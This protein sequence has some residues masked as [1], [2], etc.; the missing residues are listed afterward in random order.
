[1]DLISC[2]SY[3]MGAAELHLVKLLKISQNSLNLFT[4]ICS[5]LLSSLTDAQNVLLYITSR[6]LL[7]ETLLKD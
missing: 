1:M 2:S 5:Q 7:S 6:I 4:V 3:L